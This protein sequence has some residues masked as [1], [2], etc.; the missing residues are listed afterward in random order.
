MDVLN[1]SRNQIAGLLASG[2]LLLLVGAGSA[3]ATE[4]EMAKLPLTSPFECLTC[5]TDRDP[6]PGSLP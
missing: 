5:H 1:L 4:A 3:G 6:G 2:L